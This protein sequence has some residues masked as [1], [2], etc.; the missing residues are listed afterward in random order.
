MV[1]HAQMT[2]VTGGGASRE[3][4]QC[5]LQ[6]D[7]ILLRDMACRYERVPKSGYNKSLEREAAST[8]RERCNTDIYGMNVLLFVVTTCVIKILCTKTQTRGGVLGMVD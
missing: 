5:P 7:V 3:E 8:S 4:I 2:S 6:D 1:L